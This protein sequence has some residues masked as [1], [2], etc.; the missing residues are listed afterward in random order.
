VLAFN[1]NEIFFTILLQGDS[2]GP[3][4]YKDST[5]AWVQVGVVSFGSAG[6]CLDGPSGYARTSSFLGW[7]AGIIGQGIEQYI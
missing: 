4:V 7:M 5:G 1:E 2:G 6:G 3:L